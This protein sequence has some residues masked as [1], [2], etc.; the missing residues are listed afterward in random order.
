MAVAAGRCVQ[1]PVDKRALAGLLGEHPTKSRDLLVPPGLAGC[2]GAVFGE[3]ALPFDEDGHAPVHG[4]PTDLGFS[5]EV[6]LGEAPIG[7]LGLA[8]EEA[9]HRGP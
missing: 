6:L 7:V 9:A 1:T 3:V 2:A 4:G 8:L 5:P